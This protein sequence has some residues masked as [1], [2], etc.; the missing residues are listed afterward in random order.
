[1]PARSAFPTPSRAQRWNAFVQDIRQAAI[2]DGRAMALGRMGLAALILYDLAVR[3]SDLE[4][5]YSDAGVEP[6]SSLSRP[7]LPLFRLYFLSGSPGF[8]AALFALAAGAAVALLLGWKT[9]VANAVSWIMLGALH[10]RNS[11]VLQG[12]DDLLQMLLLWGLFLPLG[13]FWSLDAKTQ[14]PPASTRFTGSATFAFYGQLFML[15]FVTGTLKA[16]LPHWRWGNGIYDALS[17][18]YF[19][20]AFGQWL[21][22]H[23][24]VLKLLSW[25]TLLLEIGGPL[26]FFIPPQRWRVRLGLV[27]AFIGFHLGISACMRIGMF[28]FVCVVAWL[29]VIPGAVFDRLSR[30]PSSDVE[31]APA[32]P[33]RPRWAIHTVSV[34][35]GYLVLAAMVSDRWPHGRF[36]DAFL[37]PLHTMDMQAAWGMF[38]KPRSHSGWLMAKATMAEGPPRDLLR[39]NASVSNEPPGLVIDM[40]ANQRWRK[41]LTGLTKDNSKPRAERYLR[42]LCE[43]HN[44]GNS[45]PPRLLAL[46]LVYVKHEVGP[47]Y[48]HGKVEQQT[49]AS[50]RCPPLPGQKQNP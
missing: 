32:P 1:M 50:V 16:N 2:L 22:G 31:P 26:V 24:Y 6:R 34:L 21:Y 39:G 48:Q 47:R 13:A 20:T 25:G 8:T 18:D 38:V 33:L 14:P 41:M 40:F 19:V 42:W 29:F 5:L 37:K 49:L 12:G 46:D 10:A 4:A 44:R 3:S 45:P 35:F 15:Y 7:A 43:R 36:R 27:L 11:S 17:A 23:Y 9:R 28:S 30:K